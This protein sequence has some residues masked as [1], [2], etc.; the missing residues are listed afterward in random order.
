[1][2]PAW[3]EDSKP[4][5][6]PSPIEK[7]VQKYKEVEAKNAEE[8]AAEFEELQQSA[9]AVGA[10]VTKVLTPFARKLKKNAEAEAPAIIEAAGE[11]SRANSKL[12]TGILSALKNMADEVA[13]EVA[14]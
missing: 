13:D 10:K 14:K 2:N 5:P 8:M 4:K 9:K 12:V 3:A 6:T 11:Q 7:A 1:M